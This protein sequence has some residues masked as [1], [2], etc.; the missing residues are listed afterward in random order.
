MPAL[1]LLLAA[2]QVPAAQAPPPAAPLVVAHRGASGVLPEHTLPAV[3]YAHAAGA[4]YV[5]Q[6]VVLTR[7]G[8][9]V[10]LHD[11]Y[12]DAT[13]DAAAVFPDRAVPDAPPGERYP[14]FNFT[15]E[16]VK[17]LRASER[18]DPA[19][20]RAAFPRRF[21]PRTGD[22]EV[23]TLAEE[24]E[25]IRGMNRSSLRRVGVFPELKDPAA[26]AAAGLDLA[27]ATLRVLAEFG[28]EDRGDRCY[29]QCFDFD[30]SKRVRGELGCDLKLVR[31]TAPGEVLSD[32]DLAAT[33][34]VCDGLGPPLSAALA[35]ESYRFRSRGLIERAAAAGLAAFPWTA[36]RD[37]LPGAAADPAGFADL[38]RAVFDAGAA[39]IFTDFPG[40]S[41]DLARAWTGDRAGRRG[42]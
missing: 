17:R 3:A 11:I 20:G 16:E 41:A 25:L 32:A 35:F 21:P 39:G 33:A 22:F 28:Y 14:V 18:V 7:D 24:L 4:D 29:V 5:E 23:P 13:T 6:D 36:R 37:A 42:R 8:V 1:L 12:L 10:V 15:L 31:L 9:P 26:H 27:A 40:A 34:A 38:H 30:E 19:T 2:A